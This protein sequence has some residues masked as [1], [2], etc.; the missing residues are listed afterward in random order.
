MDY[1]IHG[2]TTERLSLS[3]TLKG[4]LSCHRRAS[5]WLG[6]WP[7]CQN[8]CYSCSSNSS[9]YRDLFNNDPWASYIR[10]ASCLYYKVSLFNHFLQTKTECAQEWCTICAQG[11]LHLGCTDSV[12]RRVKSQA[13]QGFSIIW[14]DCSLG[15]T[16]DA[17]CV[18]CRIHRA[19]QWMPLRLFLRWWHRTVY[20]AR[21]H[22]AISSLLEWSIVQ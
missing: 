4:K 12:C 19:Q 9:S 15:V 10:E 2:V 16:A 1:I 22:H 13:N 17:S 21:W 7:F 8:Y 18:S 6:V 14:R 5:H 3:S 20:F 11:Y